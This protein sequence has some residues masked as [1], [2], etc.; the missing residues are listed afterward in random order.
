MRTASARRRARDRRRRRR[1][2]A[3]TRMLD[4]ELPGVYPVASGR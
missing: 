4:I 3:R 2:L 1:L